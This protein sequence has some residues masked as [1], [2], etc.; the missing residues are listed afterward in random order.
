MAKE[1]EHKNINAELV[2]VQFDTDIKKRDG[3]SYKGTKIIYN[4]FDKVNEK[5]IHEST[6]EFKPELRGQLESLNSGD[7][8]TLRMYREKGA[9]FWNVDS[10]TKGHVNTRSSEGQ[11]RTQQG[12]PSSDDFVSPAAV[13]QVLRLA[14]ELKLVKSLDDFQDLGKT[15]EIVKKVQA[16]KKAIEQVWSTD[17]EPASEQRNTGPDSDEGFDDDIPF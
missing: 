3:G 7:A 16:A 4:A 9:K 11:A 17:P 14:V 10:V 15:R 1:Y 6:F 5:G 8:F 2:V 12:S 13:G